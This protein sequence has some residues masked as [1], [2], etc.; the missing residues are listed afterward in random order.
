[1]G[2]E[3]TGVMLRGGEEEVEAGNTGSQSVKGV[4]EG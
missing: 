2:R 3:G 4:R 1:M